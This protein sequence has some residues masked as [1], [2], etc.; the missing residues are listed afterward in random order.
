MG[1]TVWKSNLKKSQGIKTCHCGS[2]TMVRVISWVVLTL[3]SGW[4]G[5]KPWFQ[6]LYMSDS[7]SDRFLS[8][9]TSLGWTS[10]QLSPTNRST[11]PLGLLMLAMLGIWGN[12]FIAGPTS[13]GSI[14]NEISGNPKAVIITL[15]PSFLMR[16]TL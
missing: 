4:G 1:S 11:L 15:L 7:H 5:E 8:L 14:S 9:A 12:T 16:G 2:L 6:R 3:I 13:A 10:I